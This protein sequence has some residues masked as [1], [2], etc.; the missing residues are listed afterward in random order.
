MFSLLTLSFIRHV[1]IN[2]LEVHT[3]YLNVS[4][5]NKAIPRTT[6]YGGISFYKFI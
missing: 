1:L 5:Y 3:S 4:I 6:K 2:Y